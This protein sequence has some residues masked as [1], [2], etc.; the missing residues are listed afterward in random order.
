[1]E[2]RWGAKD[3]SK[4]CLGLRGFRFKVSRLGFKA[5]LTRFIVAAGTRKTSREMPRFF[6]S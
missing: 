1:M 3:V 6:F 2:F 4:Y 5:S